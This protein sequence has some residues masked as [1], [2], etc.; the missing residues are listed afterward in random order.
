MQWLRALL[1]LDI[2]YTPQSMSKTEVMNFLAFIHHN[3]GVIT[4]CPFSLLFTTNT[5]PHSLASSLLNLSPCS[6]SLLT[7]LNLSLFLF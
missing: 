5:D 6:S 1:H 7:S 2:K 4:A 3:P